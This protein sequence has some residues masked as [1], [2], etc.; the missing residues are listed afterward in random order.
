M[1]NPFFHNE[2][3]VEQGL[4]QDLINEAI[5]IHGIDVFYLP[6]FYLTKKTVIREVIESEFTNAFPLEAYL[7]TY[8]GYEGAGTLLTKFGI[9][10]MNDMTLTISKDRFETYISALIK[11]LPN[12]ELST[13]PKEGDLIYFPLG[14]RIFEIKFVEHEQPFY[15]LGKTYIYKLNCE[16]FRYQNEVIATGIDTVDNIIINEGFIQTYVMVGAGSSASATANI[17]NGGV[18]FVTMLNRGYDYTSAPSVKF[19]SAPSIGQTATGV[20]DMIGGIVD[21]CGPNPDKL[22]VQSVNITNS[23]F[24]YTVAPSVIFNGGGGKDAS[25]IATIG[26]GVIQTINIVNGGSGYVGIVTVSFVGIASLPA[27]GRAIIENGSIKTIVLSN[28][29]YG[30]TQPP[31]ILISSPIFVGIGTYKYNEIVVGSATGYTAR[32]RSWDATSKLLQV[33]NPTGTFLQDEIVLGTES[34]AQYKVAISSYGDNITDEYASNIDIRE[35]SDKIVNFS[36][37]N[38]FGIF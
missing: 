17:V 10:P 34:G 7:E 4:L 16:L 29:G 27:E 37:K 8:E 3:K 33:A 21:L 36:E 2:T 35:E 6:R 20:A 30:Y 13:R 19:S 24:G 32:V 26:N 5:Q 12:V 1:L 38:P 14:D 25:A 18:R 15:Q 28:T 22:R 9:Q 23:G 11:R 31:S